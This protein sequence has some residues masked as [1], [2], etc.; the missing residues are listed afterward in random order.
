MSSDIL[1]QARTCVQDLK[2]ILSASSPSPALDAASTVKKVKELMLELT[3]SIETTSDPLRLEELLE[4]NDE[5]VS[6]SAQVPESGRPVLTLQGLDALTLSSKTVAGVTSV[7][8]NGQA[9]HESPTDDLLQEE[10]P[11]TPRIDKGKARAEPEPEKQE[12]VLSP[13]LLVTESESEDE[14]SSRMAMSEANERPSPTD[15]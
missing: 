1:Y 10:D 13:N 5:L 12:K 3:R 11:L 2:T 14:D 7:V 9:F 4:V 15:R 8:N 6:L